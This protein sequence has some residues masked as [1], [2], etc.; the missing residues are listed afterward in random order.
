M[1]LVKFKKLD[2]NAK[3][4]FRANVTDA[5]WDLTAIDMDIDAQKGLVTYKTGI[6]VAIP[7]G[8]VGLLFPR[9]SVY[10][11]QLFLANSVGVIDAGYRGEIMFKYRMLSLD[12]LYKVGDRIG[13]LVIMPILDVFWDETQELPESE[14]GVGGFGA[15]DLLNRPL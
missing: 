12:P 10:K 1:T 6:A 11:Q 9:S 7:T 14:R 3:D 8:N 5:G 13:Q 4:P 15:S 2:S